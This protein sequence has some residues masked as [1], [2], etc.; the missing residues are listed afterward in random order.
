MPTI[1]R[2]P[3]PRT[4]LTTR[5]PGTPV[6]FRLVF[7]L[8]TLVVDAR[9]LWPLPLP[10]AVKLPAALLMAGASQ[11]HLWSRL[12]SGSV[13]APEFPRPIVVLFN[14]AFGFLLLLALAQLALDVGT[15]LTMLVRQE[16]VLEPVAL[17][18]AA[19]SL[20]A[21]AAAIGVAAALRVPPVRDVA[22][23]ICDLPPAFDGYRI[24]QL[25]DLHLSRLFTAKWAEAVVD[26]TNSAGGDLIVV[27]G[28][29]IDGSVAIRRA[30]V[31]PLR[32]LHAPDGVF[33]IPG[34]HEYFF[35]YRAW[36]R[37]LSSL[38]LRM[39]ANAHAMI[40]RGGRRW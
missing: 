2:R 33:G 7:A 5:T 20:A 35:D 14:W 13:F 17:R 23:Q 31:E 21:L 16:V 38:G 8:P 36:M 25:A 9:W 30:D 37:H 1:S 3:F 27:T 12:S 6:I 28:D 19:A 22:V 15:L 24:V 18:C 4:T 26:R 39:L 40:E 10:L 32:H 34:N 11:Y 29:F